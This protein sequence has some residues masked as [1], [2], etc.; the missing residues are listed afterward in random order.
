[1]NRQSILNEGLTD[2]SYQVSGETVEQYQKV[3]AASGTTLILRNLGGEEW[4]ICDGRANND[5]IYHQDKLVSLYELRELLDLYSG[6]EA[7]EAK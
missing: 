6:N 5:T 7:I 2:V 1:M 4:Q 3:D